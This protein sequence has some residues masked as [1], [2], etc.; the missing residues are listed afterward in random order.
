MSTGLRKTLFQ[1]VT[2]AFIFIILVAFILRVNVYR[3][4]PYVDEQTYDWLEFNLSQGKLRTGSAYNDV[5]ARYG[6]LDPNGGVDPWLDHP[7]LYPLILGIVKA[8]FRFAF[9]TDIGLYGSRLTSILIFCLPAIYLAMIVCK[10]R[11]GTGP[12]VITGLTYAVAP[13]IVL[14]QQMVFLDQGVALFSMLSFFALAKHLDNGGLKWLVLSSIFAGS[15]SLCKGT[16]VFAILAVV[17]TVIFSREFTVKK[18]VSKSFLALVVGGALFSLYPLYGYLLNSQL[19]QAISSAELSSH[20]I[21]TE[22]LVR[23]MVEYPWNYQNAYDL[24]LLL[25]WIAVAYLLVKGLEDRQVEAPLI[26]L[27]CY[28]AVLVFVAKTAYF[29]SQI[30]L[31][32]F[33]SIAIGKMLFDVMVFVKRAL[34]EN[35]Q[36]RR[37][38]DTGK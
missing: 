37:A 1:R 38:E 32:P 20:S 25:G 4:G 12:A 5:Y 11:Y 2:G 7:V 24:F 28:L 21:I 14:M 34:Y 23:S 8:F 36:N 10:K 6:A 30:V 15:A 31:Y 17:L 35:F 9:K 16:G 27:A 19:L 33:L 22:W 18:K 26:W 29:Y 3:L 13:S